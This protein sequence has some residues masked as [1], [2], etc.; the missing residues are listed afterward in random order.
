[1]TLQLHIDTP[2]ASLLDVVRR[3][4]PPLGP[5][6][7]TLAALAALADGPTPAAAK[8]PPAEY[9]LRFWD[10]NKLHGGAPLRAEA[11]AEAGAT[12]STLGLAPKASLLLEGR[13]PSAGSR[14]GGGGGVPAP[15]A[16]AAADDLYVRAR[17]WSRSSS[18][19][20]KAASG[21]AS[22]EDCESPNSSFTRRPSSDKRVRFARLAEFTAKLP[23]SGPAN[24][25]AA[26][27]GPN[28]RGRRLS[29]SDVSFETLRGGEEVRTRS[30]PPPSSASSVSSRRS[31]ASSE[32]GRSN[33]S[34]LSGTASETEEEHDN[35]DREEMGPRRL[36]C[37]PS[38]R[39][40]AA[41]LADVRR[42]VDATFGVP[43][44]LQRLVVPRSGGAVLLAAAGAAEGG[45]GGDGDG[46]D[47]AGDDGDDARFS[48]DAGG[49]RPTDRAG[50]GGR[51]A[52]VA[53]RTSRGE[54]E[55]PQHLL[56]RS[57]I[58]R[59]L[60]RD[61]G[62]RARDSGGA[63]VARVRSARRRRG[64]RAA[65]PRRAR[66]ASASGGDD[67]GGRARR[68]ADRRLCGVRRG[69]NAAR[70]VGA[71]RA[72]ILGGGGGA[73]VRAE[74]PR[75]QP[76]GVAAEADGPRRG[77]RRRL[78]APPVGVVGDGGGGRHRL[79]L[80][81]L[82]I[83]VTIALAVA[84]VV[85]SLFRRGLI[86][87]RRRRRRARGGG[88]GGRRRGGGGGAPTGGGGG[89]VRRRRRA[90][91]AAAA[92]TTTT[93]RLRRRLRSRWRLAARTACLAARSRSTRG[94]QSRS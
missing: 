30:P 78:D 21:G 64:G 35:S 68:G 3:A 77:R 8:P 90:R 11:L 15:W 23:T 43:R 46:E 26:S 17:M 92:A 93:T 51:R 71:A 49:R 66:R 7:A 4:L 27:H 67:G 40:A 80:V 56:Q 63:Q 9:R 41:S 18:P 25:A 59:L 36:L 24:A 29:W 39:A 72:R 52:V 32:A 45:G 75:A 57:G 16:P 13:H 60:P 83:E 12:L 73:A 1:M 14:G 62:G 44:H 37:V 20:T 5:P 79:E 81:E 6:P 89:G 50:G 53:G 48:R 22:A 28:S 55:P 54:A 94:R 61:C 74:P 85:G 58:D 2:A 31:S 82:A 65:P 47:G 34:G 33:S 87:R 69:G 91:R 38:G 70:G 10:A 86:R 76:R 19:P 42:A 88:G 84:R